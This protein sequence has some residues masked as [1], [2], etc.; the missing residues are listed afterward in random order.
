MVVV[1]GWVV[2][3]AA[4]LMIVV[5]STPIARQWR[6]IGACRTFACVSERVSQAA[7]KSLRARYSLVT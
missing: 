6:F 3:A 4:T 5:V 1:R 7:E 2:A